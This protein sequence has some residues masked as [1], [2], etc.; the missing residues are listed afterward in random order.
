MPRYIKTCFG[1]VGHTDQQAILN[2]EKA[3]FTSAQADTTWGLSSKAYLIQNVILKTR[4]LRLSR[5]LRQQLCTF[6][7]TKKDKFKYNCNK[8]AVFPED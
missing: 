6:F 2:V 8:S 7:V 5:H 4:L 3:D 1:W